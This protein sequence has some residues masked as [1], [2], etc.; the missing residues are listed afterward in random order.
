MTSQVL[1]SQLENKTY[2]HSVPHLQPYPQ[3]HTYGQSQSEIVG[4][5]DKDTKQSPFAHV[6]GSRQHCR[7]HSNHCKDG[8]LGDEHGAEERPGDGGEVEDG[9]VLEEQG[10]EGQLAHQRPDALAV[11]DVDD[12]EESEEV[13]DDDHGER[14]RDGRKEVAHGGTRRH[15]VRGSLS[16]LSCMQQRRRVTR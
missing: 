5:C 13:A 11:L 15:G 3:Q 2:T 1:I 14:L 4:L 12:P 7:Q 16:A 8:E 9:Q 6:E 10:G